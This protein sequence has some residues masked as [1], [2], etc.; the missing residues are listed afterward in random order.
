MDAQAKGIT[1]TNFFGALHYFLT[2]YI[3][4]PYLA[5]FV[6]EAMV[7][8]IF[9]AGAL[10]SLAGFL[11]IPKL[12][13]LTTLKR[14]AQIISL[15]QLGVLVG[16]AVQPPLPLI[17]IFVAMLTALPALIGYAFDIFLEQATKDEGSTGNIRG[18]FITVGNV[19]LV[20][21]PLAIGYILGDTN[22]YERIFALAAATLVPFTLLLATL[23]K[24]PKPKDVGALSLR[25]TLKCLMHS[26]DVMLGAAAHFTMLLF[27]SWVSIYIPLYLHTELGI[28]WESLGWVFSIM[29]LPYVFLEYPIG[30][31]ADRWFG[32]RELMMLGFGVM[33]ITMA[34]ISFITSPLVSL[35]LIVVLVGTRVG[36]AI[37]EITTETYFFKHV[38][39]NDIN[40]ISLFRT[41]RPLGALIGPLIG[42]L[43][44]LFVPLQSLFM[45]LGGICLIGIPIAFFLRDTR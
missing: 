41:L 31:I 42:S 40:S 3:T 30:V 5:Q 4:A 18:L 38:D 1:I 12:L 15:V 37:T 11:L 13:K 21:S 16:L 19:A 2:V 7:G 26:K 28:A 29:L 23:I 25:S 8:L 22:L 34:A 35:F 10:L 32:E 39:G 20:I 17:L 14:L 36:G 24:N 43:G 6:S 33:G 9:S 27:F 44:L 45:I